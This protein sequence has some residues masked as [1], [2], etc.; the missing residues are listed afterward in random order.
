[1]DRRKV[2]FELIDGLGVFSSEGNKAVY[3]P[4]LTLL[5]LAQAQRR[6]EN[7]FYFEQ[8]EPQLRRLL[9]QFSSSQRPSCNYPF[10][11]LRSDGYWEVQSELSDPQT[12][13][14]KSS[15]PTAKG[16]RDARA[17][18]TV[19]T[20][21]WEALLTDES[22]VP[23]LARKLIEDYWPGSIREDV[24]AAVGV[25]L[26]PTL[27]ADSRKDPEFRNKV[28][29]A[30]NFQC[31]I[32]GF[33]GRIA[34][35]IFGVEA[36]HIQ[37]RSLKLGNGPDIVQNGLALCSLHHK[38]FDYGA[39]SLDTDLRVL[40][41]ANVSGSHVVSRFL[42]DYANAELVWKPYQ[43]TAWPDKEF[44]LWHRRNLFRAPAIQ[45]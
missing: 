3:K 11:Y 43:E 34:S 25:D 5:I 16:L 26:T 33:D 23:D 21:L 29:Q 8:I 2:W 7:S 18:G 19:P 28:L 37:A 24:S 45:S 13:K 27:V 1:M 39:I 38:A 17:F 12:R 40:V 36:A 15:E 9:H 6:G 20:D 14:G 30:Y 4:L 44:T 41:S 10:W 22:L 42:R 35:E 32:C 31:A